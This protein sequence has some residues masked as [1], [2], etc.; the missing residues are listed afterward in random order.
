MLQISYPAFSSATRSYTMN[1][2]I[3]VEYPA[4]LAVGLE[5]SQVTVDDYIISQSR[6]SVVNFCSN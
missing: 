2:V 5:T 6:F 4:S 3:S 1:C